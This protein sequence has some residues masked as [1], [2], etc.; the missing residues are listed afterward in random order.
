QVPLF[1]MHQRG[2]GLNNPFEEQRFRLRS[3]QPTDLP[4]LMGMPKL[5]GIEQPN[6]F[7]VMLVVCVAHNEFKSIARYLGVD[8]YRPLVNPTEHIRHITVSTLGSQEIGHL[9]AT[10]AMVAEKDHLLVLRH[11]CDPLLCLAQRQELGAFDLSQRMLVRFT[12]ID[13]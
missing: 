10:R 5:A 4:L 3:S 12:Y 2:G 8:S 6:T 11:A 1:P 7:Q 13:Q 9:R